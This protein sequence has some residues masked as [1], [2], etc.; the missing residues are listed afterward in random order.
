MIATKNVFKNVASAAKNFK[1][2]NAPFTNGVMNNINGAK[3][4][5]RGM[6]GSKKKKKKSS[7]VLEENLTQN[8][9]GD[10]QHHSPGA[11]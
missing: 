5:V 11:D 3:K 7:E 2:K 6:A 10:C 1:A 8:I 9:I 4:F